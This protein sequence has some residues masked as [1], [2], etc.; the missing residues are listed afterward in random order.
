ML[1]QPPEWNVK[2]LGRIFS[3]E[4]VDAIT[5][6]PLSKVNKEDKHD[7][8]LRLESTQSKVAIISTNN[9]KA[10]NYAIILEWTAIELFG[11]LF[12]NSKFLMELRF[13][14]GKLANKIYPF[15]NLAKKKVIENNLCSICG[16]EEETF[17]H[18][19][20]QCPVVQDA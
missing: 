16:L 12:G 10:T 4:E 3:V 13:F 18:T 7:S 2:L 19:L 8:I 11:H 15:Q 6:I 17:G 5:G 20:W 14:Y 1:N 9:W